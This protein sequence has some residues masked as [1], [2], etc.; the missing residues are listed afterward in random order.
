MQTKTGSSR[1]LQQ[2]REEE[3]GEAQASEKDVLSLETGMG[4]K[5]DTQAKHFKSR[6]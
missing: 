4:K 5:G 6:S 3:E 2:T 1:I